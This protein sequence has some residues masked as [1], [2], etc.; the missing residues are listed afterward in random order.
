MV[1]VGSGRGARARDSDII[2]NLNP[3]VQEAIQKPRTWEMQ[4]LFTLPE[5]QQSSSAITQDLQLRHYTQS[6]SVMQTFI[7]EAATSQ[8]QRAGLAP[9]ELP[10]CAFIATLR[11]DGV[12]PPLTTATREGRGTMRKKKAVP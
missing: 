10:E 2:F 1:S 3:L 6:N 4:P 12:Q 9:P 5:S 8:Q 7:S 11:R